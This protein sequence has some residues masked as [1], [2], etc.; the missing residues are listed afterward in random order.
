M[1]DGNETK[2]TSS[3]WQFFCSTKG[4]SRKSSMPSLEKKLLD[5]ES[6]V[7]SEPEI[8]Q[9]KPG[10][11]AMP[12]IIGNETIE[13]L[14]TFGM[15]AN[16]MVYLLREYNMDQVMAANILNIWVGVCNVAP[17]MGAF[18][19]DAYLGKFRTIVIASFAT[20]VGMVIVTLTAWVPQFHPPPCTVQKQQLDECIGHTKY[21]LYILLLGLFWLSIGTGGIKPCS[22]PFAIDQFD[23]TT[24][25]GRKGS[26]RFY[27]WYY[28]SF[29]VIMLINQTIVVY[30]Q[31]SVS[32]TLGFSLPAL[33][34]L[35]AIILFIAGRKVYVYVQPEGT[36][37]SSIAQVFIAAYRN[38]HLQLPAS[39]DIHDVF[40]D[41]PVKK[42]LVLKMPLTNQ[43]RFLN[44]SALIVN[45]EH[46]SNS[47]GLCTVQEV[48][49]LKAL[50]KLLP[51]WVASVICFI[52]IAQQGTFPISQ[53]LKM[54][55]HLGS[56]E[57]PAGSLG[58]ISLV[59]VA[60]FLPLYDS[61]LTPIIA[62]FTKREEGITTLQRIGLGHF[63][64]I[65]TMVVAAFVERYRR[66]LAIS[67]NTPDE[68][69]PMS[70]MWL[71]PQ[72]VLLGM[73][74]VFNV[75]GHTE[76]YN[77][78]APENMRSIANSLFCLTT[79]G[80]SYLLSL[81]VN[82]VHNFTGQHGQP[83]WLDNDINAG[84]LDYFY[85]LIAGLMVLNFG[86]YIF[87]ARRYHY[88]TVVVA[89]NIIVI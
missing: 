5:D 79:A 80:S 62:K 9:T 33:L 56:F 89:D 77:K 19:A 18:V 34:M 85:F 57:I 52:S 71:A 58:V 38:R 50:L 2:V 64:S 60:I 15:T 61:I 72:F 82:I 22:V 68:V 83:D 30:I 41:P 39:E 12:Y 63:I 1:V 25:E 86:Y 7:L 21:Q 29:T 40:Y 49:E 24:I 75:V 65:L 51:V 53:A 74:E 48:E 88:K 45:N 69:A 8:N 31:D 32:W 59:T 20:L 4:N 76:F 37:F 6:L 43:L 14:A 17:L 36:I 47:C 54:D 16:F 27:N 23:L 81:L 70:A 13:R 42:N 67:N 44:K 35:W 55:R 46:S 84:R 11:K 28:T 66:S 73:C 78:E 10:W 3:F 87:C 26:S